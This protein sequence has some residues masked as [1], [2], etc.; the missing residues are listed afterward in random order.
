[1][2]RIRNAAGNGLQSNLLPFGLIPRTHCKQEPGMQDSCKQLH[3]PHDQSHYDVFQ[4]LALARTQIWAIQRLEHVFDASQKRTSMHVECPRSSLGRHVLASLQKRTHWQISSHEVLGMGLDWNKCT[5]SH[6]I[7]IRLQ[8]L[9][10]SIGSLTRRPAMHKMRAKRFAWASG[11]EHS[12][13]EGVIRGIASSQGEGG[14]RNRQK[15]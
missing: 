6:F 8:W 9:G 14:I 4:V 13:M 1:M 7:Q 15:Y 5:A 12:I 2:T 10:C 11:S 3:A